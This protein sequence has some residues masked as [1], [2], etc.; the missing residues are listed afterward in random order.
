ML[1]KHVLFK[2]FDLAILKL[3]FVLAIEHT[4]LGMFFN[5]QNIWFPGDLDDA[6]LQN[7]CTI[8]CRT[9]TFPR[10]LQLPARLRNYQCTFT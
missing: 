7:L 3:L 8:E 2:Y 5:C 10:S 9:F 1:E 4:L 6:A